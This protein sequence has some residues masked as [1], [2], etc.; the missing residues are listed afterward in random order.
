MIYLKKLCQKDEN[1]FILAMQKSQH[2]HHPFV[3]APCH[4][5]DF[6]DLLV[7]SE[8]ENNQT[9]LVMTDNHQIAGVFNIN[10]IVRGAF[11]SAYLGFYATVDYAGKGFM[12]L[13]LKM[14]L[15]EAFNELKL[16]RVEANIQPTNTS[17]IHLVTQNQFRK[18]G[19]S[20]RYL[21]I[22]NTWQDHFRYALTA[23][24]WQLQLLNVF[25][26]TTSF[27]GN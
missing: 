20:P 8:S 19:F 18:E 16:H 14:L 5:E 4:S 23:E 17:S 13:G 6:K 12:S 24:E 10:E 27:K 9:F 15:H 2:F 11:Q 22:N 1:Q 25:S 3:A 26:I 21:K 7:K